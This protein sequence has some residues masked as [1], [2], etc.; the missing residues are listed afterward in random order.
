MVR[1]FKAMAI[2]YAVTALHVSLIMRIIA[3]VSKQQS[4]LSGSAP[5]GVERSK[6]ILRAARIRRK[7]RG[8]VQLASRRATGRRIHLAHP[9]MGSGHIAADAPLTRLEI[10]LASGLAVR[11]KGGCAPGAQAAGRDLRGHF[12]AD[13]VPI[14]AGRQLPP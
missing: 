11:P 4:S 3:E 9:P 8:P 5:Q 10:S 12:Q 14:N 7:R 1:G 2:A 6:V 13:T